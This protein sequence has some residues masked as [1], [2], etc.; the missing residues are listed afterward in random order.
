MTD[1]WL[2]YSPVN[3]A[4]PHQ[5]SHC[6]L[7]P[8]QLILFPGVSRTLFCEVILSIFES[9]VLILAMLGQEYLFPQWSWISECI[10]QWSFLSEPDFSSPV[11]INHSFVPVLS[12]PMYIPQSK[13]PQHD[14]AFE[15][16]IL[17][18]KSCYVFPGGFLV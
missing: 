18:D 1:E 3:S 7:R 2:S 17:G 13:S 4:L 11:K 5:S 14:L 16:F 9:F 12:T 6:E 10:P 8:D 15:I